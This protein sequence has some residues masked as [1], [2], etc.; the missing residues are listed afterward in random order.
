MHEVS[1]DG[2]LPFYSSTILFRWN[3][4][5]LSNGAVGGEGILAAVMEGEG[6]GNKDEWFFLGMGTMNDGSKDSGGRAMGTYFV[7]SKGG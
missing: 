6:R 4:L 2:F 1:F 3:A 7:S 5:L